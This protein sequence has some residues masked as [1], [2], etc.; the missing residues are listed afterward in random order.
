MPLWWLQHSRGG[1]GGGGGGKEG[2]E[3]EGRERAGRERAEERGGEGA[4]IQM[5]VIPQLHVPIKGTMPYFV[6]DEYNKIYKTTKAA[7]S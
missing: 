3:G 5:L 2:G 4:S 1:G 6:I 7:N